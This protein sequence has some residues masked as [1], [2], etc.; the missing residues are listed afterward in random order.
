MSGDSIAET[1]RQLDALRCSERRQLLRRVL[2]ASENGENPVEMSRIVPDSAGQDHRVAMHHVHL[3]K[4]EELG[5]VS[6]EGDHERVG[7]GPAFDR[8][9]PLLRFLDDYPERAAD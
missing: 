6:V 5:Y 1:D 3:P 2:Q 8:I 7:R 9:K 4:L